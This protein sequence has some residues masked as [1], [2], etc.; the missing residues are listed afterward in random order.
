MFYIALQT[1]FSKTFLYYTRVSS[2]LESVVYA[3]SWPS[4]ESIKKMIECQYIMNA[5]K[6]PVS[7]QL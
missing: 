3:T 6:N 4:K 7:S 2:K 5:K 1:S